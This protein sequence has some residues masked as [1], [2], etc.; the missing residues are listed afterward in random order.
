M[1]NSVVLVN[2]YNKLSDSCFNFYGML[3]NQLNVTVRLIQMTMLAAGYSKVLV[4]LT[5][6][7]LVPA[8]AVSHGDCPP[9]AVAPLQTGG[10]Y[11]LPI[12]P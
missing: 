10:H 3:L 4:A 2:N 12:Y 5:P 6:G 9:K 11:V 1:Y 7:L 8:A